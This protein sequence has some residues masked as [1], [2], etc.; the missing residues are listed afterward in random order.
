MF[1]RAMIRK[2]S[3]TNID[4]IIPPYLQ[5][6]SALLK[7][8]LF[9]L[10]NHLSYLL[11]FLIPNSFFL[12]SM[13]VSIQFSILCGSFIGISSYTG[14]ILLES[15]QSINLKVSEK[16]AN[17]NEKDKI[18]IDNGANSVVAV[19]EMLDTLPSK[20]FVQRV[21]AAH[22][23]AIKTHDIG[24]NKIQHP[25]PRNDTHNNNDSE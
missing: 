18:A 13:N 24:F 1:F 20:S 6:S 17:H 15:Q 11:V 8:I 25:V 9:I 5:V 2:F 22:D 3:S 19:N 7:R 4:H 16:I 14:L 21:E 10:F 12:S 23:A